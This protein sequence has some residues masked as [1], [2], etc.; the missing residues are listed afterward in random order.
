MAQTRLK[1]I[2]NSP[3]QLYRHFGE[4]G[5]L[6]YI[7]ISLSVTTRLGQHRLT[8]PWF[9]KIS[10]IEVEHFSNR[11][12]AL[13]AEKKAIKSESPK[14]NIHHNTPDKVP[15]PAPELISIERMSLTANLVDKP[16]YNLSEAAVILGMGSAEV[17]KLFE[18]GEL[19][20]FKTPGKYKF[21]G[22]Q[23]LEYLE[24]IHL[25]LE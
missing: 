2:E 23:I 1:A 17:K 25:S 11:I 14:F 7:G 20:G 5:E 16:W 15:T 8:S 4:N 24:M 19:S 12:D 3:H 22:W 13:N 10:R 9:E 18:S 21:S 6:L